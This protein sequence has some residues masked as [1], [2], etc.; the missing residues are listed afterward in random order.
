MPALQVGFNRHLNA[1]ESIPLLLQ[2]SLTEFFQVFQLFKGIQ[3]F[4]E[5]EQFTHA[6]NSMLTKFTGSSPERAKAFFWSP[7]NGCLA[8]LYYYATFLN[9][10]SISYFPSFPPLEKTCKKSWMLGSH[11]IEAIDDEKYATTEAILN[12][13]HRNIRQIAKELVKVIILLKENENVLFFLLRHR[14]QLDDIYGQ[15]FTMKLI[16]SLF[17]RGLNEAQAHLIE[18]YSSRGFEKLSETIRLYFNEL[19]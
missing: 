6:L 8:K 9:D 7:E 4:V 11:L 10:H 3:R 5:A 13:L 19:Q 12:K 15:N 2:F 1:Y 16:A 17:T 14:M 18:R